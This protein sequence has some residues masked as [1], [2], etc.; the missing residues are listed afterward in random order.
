M[1]RTCCLIGRCQTERKG[2]SR[3][4]TNINIK[5]KPQTIFKILVKCFLS[6][7]I[8]LDTFSLILLFEQRDVMLALAYA[9][10]I[11]CDNVSLESHVYVS[12]FAFF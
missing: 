3:I 6:S 5:E 1:G 9:H 10:A 8:F 11:G 4:H 2:I 12:F 7:A